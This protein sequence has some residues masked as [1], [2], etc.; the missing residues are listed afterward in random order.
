MYVHVISL[1]P[2]Q[3]VAEMKD[4]EYYDLRIYSLYTLAPLG[5][6]SLPVLR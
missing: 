4:E 5:N 2:F 3:I 1:R 6:A